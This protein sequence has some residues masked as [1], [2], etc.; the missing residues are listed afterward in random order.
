MTWGESKNKLELASDS[1]LDNT[2]GLQDKWTPIVTEARMHLAQDSEAAGD[3]V[4]SGDAV[5]PASAYPT[6]VSQGV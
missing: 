1:G 3:P 2:G 4:G 5:D 6:K